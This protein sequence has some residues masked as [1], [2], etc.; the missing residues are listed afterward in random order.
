[1]N[2]WVMYYL[3]FLNAAAHHVRSAPRND[4]LQS[5]ETIPMWPLG[6]KHLRVA[7]RR[8]SVSP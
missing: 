3:F 4:S 5:S 6:R 7:G 2:V 8:T 1:M